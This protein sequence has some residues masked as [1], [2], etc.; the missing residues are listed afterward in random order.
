MTT[1]NVTQI[2]AL[3]V[4]LIAT[5]VSLF[6]LCFA[7]STITH[8]ALPT[9]SYYS[10]L[11]KYESNDA[12]LRSYTERGAEE[13]QKEMAATVA[14]L[15]SQPPAQLEARRLHD[16]QIFLEEKRISNIMGII[17]SLQWI[18]IAAV[19]LYIHYCIYRRASTAV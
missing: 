8:L 15:R 9:Y 18:G 3:L 17:G 1:K 16:R 13:Y 10:E 4:C 11:S 2:Y 6:S 14:D 5:I 12:Y 7:V 19:F